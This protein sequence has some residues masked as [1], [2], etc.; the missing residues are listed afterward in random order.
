MGFRGLKAQA[1]SCGNRP[2]RRAKFLNELAPRPLPFLNNSEQFGSDPIGS[3]A[4]R[5]VEYLRVDIH[6]GVHFRMPVVSENSGDTL[7]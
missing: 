5:A 7:A 4:R 6:R 3:G 2:V 1:H